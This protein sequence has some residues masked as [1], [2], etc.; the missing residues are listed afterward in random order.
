[1]KMK[2][3]I[4]IY[5]RKVQKITMNKRNM[6]ENGFETSIVNYLLQVNGYEEGYNQDYLLKD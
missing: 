2:L 1:M 5:L 4:K 3:L 6:N